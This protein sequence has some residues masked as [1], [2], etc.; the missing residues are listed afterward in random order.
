MFGGVLLVLV[1]AMTMPWG[2]LETKPW[3]KVYRPTVHHQGHM[4]SASSRTAHAT[5]RSRSPNLGGIKWAVAV[6]GCWR[7]SKVP[8]I[9]YGHMLDSKRISH[10][11]SSFTQFD[12]VFL[13]FISSWQLDG[14]CIWVLA[15]AGTPRMW[16][17]STRAAEP[18][19]LPLSSCGAPTIETM[20]MM[21]MP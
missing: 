16:I 17:S 7:R 9:S 19:I 12:H 4:A 14:L 18:E 1:W 6:S 13:C 20:P 15:V 2:N 10:L 11:V 21:Q 3:K 8:V 5:V